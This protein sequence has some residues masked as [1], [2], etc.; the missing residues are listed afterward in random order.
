MSVTPQSLLESRY[1]SRKMMVFHVLHD[2][3]RYAVPRCWAPHT[4]YLILSYLM[5]RQRSAAVP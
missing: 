5:L 3:R 4:Q 1:A 2:L